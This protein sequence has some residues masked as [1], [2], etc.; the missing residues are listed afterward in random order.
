MFIF[1]FDLLFIII[2]CPIFPTIL[3]VFCDIGLLFNFTSDLVSEIFN[4]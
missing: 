4:S 3:R 2:L 1:V